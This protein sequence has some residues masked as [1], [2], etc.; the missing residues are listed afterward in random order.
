MPR[1]AG[2]A[3]LHGTRWVHAYEEDTADGA[4][5]RPDSAG[6]P[7]SRRPRE[8]FELSED[9]SASL[10]VGGPDDRLLV[11]DAEWKLEGDDVVIRRRGTP[12]EVLRIIARAPDRL[13]VR[14]P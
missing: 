5:Y 7:P 14:R 1:G 8:Q 13:V 9:G 2:G 11:R 10:Y 3:P 6:L 4:V 12:A